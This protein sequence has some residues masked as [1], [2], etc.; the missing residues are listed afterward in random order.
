MDD[1]GKKIAL[2]AI[3][4]KAHAIAEIAWPRDERGVTD[5]PLAALQA[6]MD[7]Q[8][9]AEKALGL[10]PCDLLTGDPSVDLT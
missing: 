5:M 8:T 6:I 7:V 10:P 3:V 1:T 9:A 4:G 2:S